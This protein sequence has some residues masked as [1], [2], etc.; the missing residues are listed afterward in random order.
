MKIAEIFVDAPRLMRAFGLFGL[1]SSDLVCIQGPDEDCRVLYGSI[2]MLLNGVVWFQLDAFRKYL[3]LSK[4][5]R[6]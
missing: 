3:A 6:V 1:S 4:S 2:P 5:Q